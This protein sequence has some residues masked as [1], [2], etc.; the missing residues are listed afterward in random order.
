MPEPYPSHIF[1][2]HDRGGEHLMLQKNRHGWVLVTEAIGADPN[3]HGG[4]NYT[5]LTNQGLGVLVRLN[6]GYGMAGTIPNSAEY[7]AFAQRCGNFVQASPGCQIWIIGN[8]MNLAAE[9]PGGPNGQVI[10]PE[11]YA[12]CFRECRNEIRRRPGHAGDQVV[13]GAVGPWN[14]QTK[15]AGNP[16]GDWV[17]YLADILDLL[18]GE[19]DGIALHTYTHGQQ[20]D[21]VFDDATMGPPFQDRHYHF[22]AYRD[23]MAAIP[24]SLRD[25]PVYLTETDQYGAWLDDNTGWVR[26]AYREIDTWNQDPANQPIQALILFRWII[27]N[28]SDPQQVGWAISN[29][30]GVQTDWLEAMNNAYAVVLPAAK[31]AYLVEWPE[32]GAPGRMEPGSTVTFALTVRNAGRQPWAQT[33]AQAVRVGYR[34]YGADGAAIEGEERANLPRKVEPG[35]TVSVAAMAVQAPLRPGFYVLELDLVEGTSTWFAD[36]GSPTWRQE[37]VRIG[38]RYRVKWL[39]VDA[40]QEGIESETVTVPVRMRN[41]GSLTWLPGG[42]KPFNLSYKWL[43]ANREVVVADGRRTQLGREVAPLDEIALNARVQMPSPAGAHILQMDMVHEFVTWFHWQ[44][45]PAAEFEVSVQ[46]A[47]PDYAAQWL[48]YI[49]PERLTVGQAGLAHLEVKNTGSLPWLRSGS[50]AVSLGYRWLD[51]QGQEVPVAGAEPVPLPGTAE[52]GD[53]VTFRDVAFLTPAEPGS[54]LL[55]WDLVQ[56]GAWLSARGVAVLQ[57]PLQLVAPGYG[58]AWEVLQPW[59]AWMPPDEELRAGLQLHNT[60]STAWPAGGEYPVHLAYN[61]FTAVGKPAEP[62][63]TFRF[64]LPRDVP[65]G[66]SLAL[67]D[68]PFKTPAVLGNYILRWDL[69]AEGLTWFFRQGA[70]PLEVPVEVSDRGL[71]VPWTAEASHNPDDVALAFDGNPDTSWSTAASQEPGMWFQV[72]LGQV[73]ELDRVRVS[74][75]GRGFPVGYRVKLSSDGHDWHL[76]AERPRN[77]TNVDVAFPPLSARYL[78]L[79]QTGQPSWWAA[80]IIS[81]ISVSAT[82][83]WP[84]A[85]ASHYTADAQRAIDAHLHTS[86]NTRAVKQKPGMWFQVDMGAQRHIERVTLGHP[87]SQMPRGYIVRTSVDGTTWQEVGRKADNWGRVDVAFPP[88]AARY[89]QVETT[90]SSTSHPWGIVEFVVWRSSPVWLVGRR[91]T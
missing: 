8:E 82:G 63:D 49:G 77:W 86:W 26:N 59:P 88:L 68:I 72:D 64:A 62:W 1:G 3:N 81:E 44:G 5:D 79:E 36:K 91:S 40:P 31:P 46:P 13:V 87:T 19:V 21:L 7:D 52:P 61:W 57:R 39:Q 85:Q 11:L 43:D 35:Q 6:N 9:R 20:P 65:P 55:T 25:R 69:V 50:D 67:L 33:G 80:W 75:P 60:G 45:S 56:A 83:P 89:V 84:G 53:V 18:G 73:L 10:T 32:V 16:S 78:R 15:Y 23:F 4:S 2:M 27:G 58:V 12:S 41:E 37:N 22:R 38:D 66:D 24:A 74:S 51:P 17:K 34:W 14:N 76:V 29:K 70:A 28:A 54:Y 48:E 71:F 90:G 42:D 30:P 47:V